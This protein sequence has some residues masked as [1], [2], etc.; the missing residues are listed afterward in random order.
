MIHLIF[1]NASG[2][3]PELLIDNANHA[4]IAEILDGMPDHVR[5]PRR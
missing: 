3:S 4:E 2:A 5:I 1:A